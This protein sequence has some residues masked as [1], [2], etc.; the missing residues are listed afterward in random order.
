LLIEDGAL[1]LYGRTILKPNPSEELC[2]FRMPEFCFQKK[3][4]LKPPDSLTE[5][6]AKI[7]P[8]IPALLR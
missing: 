4:A 2:F 8:K 3:Q 6:A 5:R 7:K 1:P